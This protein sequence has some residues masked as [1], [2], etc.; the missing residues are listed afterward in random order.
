MHATTKHHSHVEN[1]NS[2][3]TSDSQFRPSTVN[4]SGKL[5]PQVN[6]EG[7][8]RVQISAPDANYVQLDIGGIKYDLTKDNNGLWT[9]ES[10]PQDEGFHYY[11]LNID[12][13]SVP[14]PG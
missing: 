2:D 1:A 5:F 7:K 4:Q 11:Q 6:N 3:L 13:A 8:V 12:G 10:D 9:G 14:D